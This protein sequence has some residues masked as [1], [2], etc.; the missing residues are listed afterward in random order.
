MGGAG[1]AS[2]CFPLQIMYQLKRCYGQAS[3]QQL[4]LGV[5]CIKAPVLVVIIIELSC[6][7][8]DSTFF[9]GR[10]TAPVATYRVARRRYRLLQGAV[11]LALPS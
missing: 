9:R 4:Q 1:G 2:A 11:R 10:V 3:K 5:F 7:S 8:I 6:K